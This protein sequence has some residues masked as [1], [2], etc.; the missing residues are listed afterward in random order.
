MK[1]KINLTEDEEN[2]Y[3]RVVVHQEAVCF[4]LCNRTCCFISFFLSKYQQ[5]SG[6]N[7]TYLTRVEFPK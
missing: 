6:P 1:S 2:E 4:V 3:Q 5:P 7:P